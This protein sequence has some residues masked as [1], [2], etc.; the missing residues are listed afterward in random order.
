[1]SN[2]GPITASPCPYCK[3]PLRLDGRLLRCPDGVHCQYAA[4][5]IECKG[6]RRAA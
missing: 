3:R 1:V 5:R 4:L 2:L 6:T